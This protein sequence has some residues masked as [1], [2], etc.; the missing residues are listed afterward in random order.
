[1]ANLLS[2]MLPEPG[3]IIPAL[4]LARALKEL[5]HTICFVTFDHFHDEIRRA[6]FDCASIRMARPLEWTG[7]NLL[8]SPL[9]SYDLKD[10]PP[11]EERQ[12]F[13]SVFEN[14]RTIKPDMVLV[15]RVLVH[16]CRFFEAL[17]VRY[18]LVGTNFGDGLEAL[19]SHNLKRSTELLLCPRSIAAV[20]DLKDTSR[21]FFDTPITRDRLISSFRWDMIDPGKPLVYCSFGTQVDLYP[22]ASDILREIIHYLVA[23]YSCQIVAVAG[24]SLLREYGDFGLPGVVLTPCAPQLDLIER[25]DALVSHGGLGTIKEALH[26]AVPMFLVPFA[27]DQ[28]ANA[29]RVVAAG[30]GR[31]LS[32]LSWSRSRFEAEYEAFQHGLPRLR[33]NLRQLQAHSALANGKLSLNGLGELVSS[34]LQS[35]R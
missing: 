29:D 5:G 24:A 4:E 27:H 17:H 1:M 31:Q 34:V 7:T 33:E 10:A 30:G 20:E 9:S 6:G 26:F 8:Y 32:S 13:L 28:F 3:H 35:P 15:D 23:T 12:Y 14:L 22:E 19:E 16:I 21:Y 11:E 25:A 2:I 18:L